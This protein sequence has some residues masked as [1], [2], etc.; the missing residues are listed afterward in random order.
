[1]SGQEN[2]S[3]QIEKL[4][5]KK[6]DLLVISVPLILKDGQ[7]E[8]IAAML[9]G[10]AD[11]LDCEVLVLEAGV[12]AELHPRHGDMLAEQ[13]KQTQLL[14]QI[15]DNQAVLIQAMAEEQE[16]DDE[17]PPSHYLDGSPCL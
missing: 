9:K 7:R 2:Y 6:G 15:A 12:T 14:Q 1:M 17:A 5:P 16:P 10:T 11:R 8:K 4:S 3:D 13:Q